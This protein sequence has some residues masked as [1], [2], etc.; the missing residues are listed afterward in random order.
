MIGKS[1]GIAEG[2]REVTSTWARKIPFRDGYEDYD[3]KEKLEER[4]KVILKEG[5]NYISGDRNF[6]GEGEEWEQMKTFCDNSTRGS[7]FIFS[8]EVI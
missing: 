8:M 1:G 5:E 4:M 3:G 7:D 6:L 2:R